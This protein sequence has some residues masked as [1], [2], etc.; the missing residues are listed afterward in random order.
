M[1]MVHFA[2]PVSARRDEAQWL[3]INELL[4]LTL[5]SIFNQTSDR[6]RVFVCGHDRPEVLSEDAFSAVEFIEVNFP[7]PQ[8]DKAKR[9]DKRSKRWEIARRVRDVGGGYYMF[10]DADDLVHRDLVHFI[11]TDDNQVGYL[12]N[13]GYALDFANRRVAPIP[14]AFNMGFNR[15][16]GS[17]GAVYLLPEDL[18]NVEY[19]EEHPDILYTQIRNHKYF[20]EGPMRGG[21]TL[22]AVPFPA[23]VYTLNNSINL[24]N[25]LVRTEERQL[26]L[27][28]GIKT[29]ALTDLDSLGREFGL[30]TFL[31]TK[32]MVESAPKSSFLDTP[33]P[34]SW[35]DELTAPETK[36]LRATTGGNDESEISSKKVRNKDMRLSEDEAM[37]L[38]RPHAKQMA[39]LLGYAKASGWL[40][41]ATARRPVDTDGNPLPWYTYPAISFLTPRI[42]PSLS[43]FEYGSG[44][45]TLWWAARV[46]KVRSV[47]HDS[48]WAKIV[49]DM[50]PENASLDVFEL[51]DGGDY[52]KASR[53]ANE[54]FD[55]IVV[56]GRDRINCAHVAV[57]ALTPGGVLVWDNTERRRYHSGFKHLYEF[58]FKRLE[59]RGLA[60]IRSIALETSIFY[61]PDNCLGI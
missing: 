16:C 6:Y 28:E 18:P 61:R 50:L 60:P 19:D 27:I 21:K 2:I 36:P 14:G 22:T 58:G 23:G 49:R 30:A 42:K 7:L 34:T 48:A 52:S 43:V 55:V 9:R 11:T 31:K 41:S 15:V 12:I 37:E 45:S 39:N 13:R 46:R 1:S 38:L 10:M 3:R 53:T 29:L 17:S 59:F 47:E 25:L 5:G 32:P 54:K 51:E 56:D 8:N 24:S 26:S 33:S 40:R 20:E 4:R 44:N 57:T 35:V